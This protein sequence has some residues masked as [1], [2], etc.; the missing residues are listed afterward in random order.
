MLYGRLFSS[1][2]AAI[3][4]IK[5]LQC[6]T[7]FS[8]GKRNTDYSWVLL[9]GRLGRNCDHKLLTHRTLSSNDILKWSS[10]LL[11]SSGRSL[12]LAKSVV[13]TKI[14]TLSKGNLLRFARARAMRSLKKHNEAA[15]TP[16]HLP[17][18]CPG[19]ASAAQEKR[20]PRS[21]PIRRP[22]SRGSSHVAYRVLVK[23]VALGL[24][25]LKSPLPTHRLRPEDSWREHVR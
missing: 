6:A 7:S 11:N 14:Q 2:V 15:K 18:A 1:R 16:I 5:L 25:P 3:A 9:F 20:T 22:L 13:T 17:C 4:T 23:F 12:R 10:S 21:P 8:R 24:T 19:V